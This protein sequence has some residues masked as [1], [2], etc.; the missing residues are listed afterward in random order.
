MTHL[1]RILFALLT[2]VIL[3]PTVLGQT[4]DRIERERMKEMLTN[5]KNAVKKTITTRSITVS[6]STLDLKRPRNGW[7]KLRRQDKLSP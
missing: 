6:T 5:I 3:I 4:M 2:L 1:H 7:M